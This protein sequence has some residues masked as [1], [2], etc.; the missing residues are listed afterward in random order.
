MVL[1]N[2]VHVPHALSLGIIAG[3][4]GAGVLASIVSSRR[5]AAAE[6]AADKPA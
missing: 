4:I 2:H 1:H 3:I 5:A 6:A